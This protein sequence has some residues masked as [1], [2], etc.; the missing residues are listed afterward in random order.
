MTRQV[1]SHPNPPQIVFP[2]TVGTDELK[3]FI[4]EKISQTLNIL[5]PEID[6]SNHT[7]E[8]FLRRNKSGTTQGFL[9]QSLEVTKDPKYNK[10]TGVS[11]FGEVME[12]DINLQKGTF[13]PTDNIEGWLNILVHEVIHYAQTAAG[14]F[15]ATMTRDMFGQTVKFN[16]NSNNFALLTQ[17]VY[18]AIGATGEAWGLFNNYSTEGMT[19]TDGYDF[20]YD[21]A[22]G[23]QY[24]HM[25]HEAQ[26][27]RQS[28][29]ITKHIFK[30][31]PSQMH[32]NGAK[33]S[34]SRSVTIYKDAYYQ[35]KV[36]DYSGTGRRILK[37]VPHLRP[38]Q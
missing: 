16:G 22:K 26:A 27:W 19:L 18:E 21:R 3:D 13:T 7:L 33:Y 25:K 32:I 2:K 9:K 35:M 5:T 29:K 12:L 37:S 31:Q 4:A 1:M 6:Y 11:V 8:V 24:H 30:V 28:Y 15:Q 38:T 10:I 17:R 14:C 34:L 23:L 36:G 20:T